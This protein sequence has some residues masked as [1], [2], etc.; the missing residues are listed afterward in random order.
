MP[1]PEIPPQLL[2]SL[3]QLHIDDKKTRISQPALASLGEYMKT[4]VREA[5]YRAAEE[6]KQTDSANGF[7][8][9]MGSMFLEVKQCSRY[10]L[11]QTNDME[12][13]GLGESRA[14]APT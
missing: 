4:F 10:I 6:R 8:T 13:R 1:D 9:A 12:G 5:I 2:Q 7:S 14:P 11:S 3:L